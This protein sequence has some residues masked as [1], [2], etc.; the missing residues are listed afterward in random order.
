MHH[1]A[2]RFVPSIRATL[3]AALVLSAAAAAPTMLAVVAASPA[4]AQPPA[5]APSTPATVAASHGAA[6]APGAAAVA[7]SAPAAAPPQEDAALRHARRLLRST[8]LIDGHNDLPIA[9]R[10]Y[11]PAPSD[12]VA[13]DLRG[14][15]PGE[16]DIPRLREGLV[17]A[18]FWSVYIPGEGGGPYGRMQLEQIDLA[19]RIIARYPDSF[20]LAGT[21]AEIRAAHRAGRIASLLGMEGG[22]GL[23]NSLGP[24]RAYYDL[25]VRYMTLTHNTHTDWADSAGQLPPRHGGLTPFGEEVVREMNRLGMLVDLAHTSAETMADALRVSEAPVIWSHASA[26]GVCDVP[27]NV[28]DEILRE[29][30]RNGGVVMV[31]FVA[32]FVDCEVAK[33]TV[34][35]SME[36]GLRARAAGS[37]EERRRILTEGL[38]AIQAPPT[39]IGKVADHIEHVRRVAG[40]DHIGIGGDFD[41]NPWWPTGL[42]DVSMYPNLFA[43]LVRR[44]WSDRDLRKLAGENLLRAMAQA[45]RVARRLQASRPAS[46]MRFE[47]TPRQNP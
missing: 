35:A 43:E 29:L 11:E 42:S 47:A 12:V 28:S 34:P 26:R 27:R 16:T 31:T 32:P 38:K 44:G 9:M 6:P 7:A 4:A 21:A 45:E 3:A 22:Y 15:S 40:V 36:L 17:G 2:H 20:R 24:L 13:Y 41:G 37:A 33:V 30:P 10:G 14:R 18:Q 39:S 25:G 8:I 1:F 5:S 19:R 46:T 23:E